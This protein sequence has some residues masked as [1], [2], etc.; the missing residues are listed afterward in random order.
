[1]RLDRHTG[2]PGAVDQ[3]AAVRY[4]RG[5]GRLG[6]RRLCASRR[7]SLPGQHGRVGVE[8]KADLTA[9]LSYQRREPIREQRQEISRP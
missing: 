1:L 8:A 6:G 4:N 7:R 5:G 9:T 2:G 3:E